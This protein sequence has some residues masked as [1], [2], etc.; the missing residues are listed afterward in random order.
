MIS[1]GHG[2]LLFRVVLMTSLIHVQNGDLR[3][4]FVISIGK[5]VSV[6][7]AE[8]TCTEGNITLDRSKMSRSYNGSDITYQCLSTCERRYPVD[9]ATLLQA[10]GE[11]KPSR[12][13]CIHNCIGSD[14]GLAPPGDKPLSEPM[15]VSPQCPIHQQGFSVWPA[16]NRWQ[17]I[18]WN[19]SNLQRLHKT[20]YMYI[21][22]YIYI[23]N[24]EK[25]KM[26]NVAVSFWD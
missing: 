20:I 16:P 12:C 24:H 18:Y 11:G 19:D 6:E 25:Q 26:L 7:P 1:R 8:A 5:P 23:Y 22:M 15:M 2:T 3:I 13:S 10:V 17:T 21:Y 14:N 4:P 9:H